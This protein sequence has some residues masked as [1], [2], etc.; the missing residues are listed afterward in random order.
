M[1]GCSDVSPNQEACFA[2]PT[3]SFQSPTRKAPL[4]FAGRPASAAAGVR[5]W[6]YTTSKRGD[7]ETSPLSHGHR[8]TLSSGVGAL[9]LSENASAPARNAKVEYLVHGSWFQFAHFKNYQ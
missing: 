9:L 3:K 1:Q 2:G 5:R 8:L 7:S 6:S 4:A